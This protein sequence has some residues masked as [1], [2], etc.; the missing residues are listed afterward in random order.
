MGSQGNLYP[1]FPYEQYTLMSDQ[2]IVDLYA[3]LMATEPVSTPAPTSEI[4]FPFN[5]RLAVAGWK[6]L[7]FSPGRFG[8]ETGGS[9]TCNRGKYLAFG[10]AHCV[11]H[12]S[13]RNTLGALDWDQALTGSPG[14]VGGKAPSLT[15]TAL[16]EGAMMSKAWPKRWLTVSPSALTFWVPRWAR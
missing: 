8:P 3:A 15:R 14:G 10:P 4:A 1:V 13:P 5:I 16:L 11:A 9:E 7:F 6:N 12:H 2:E